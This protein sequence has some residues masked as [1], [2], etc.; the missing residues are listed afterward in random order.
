MLGFTQ[1]MMCK[2][3][4]INDLSD[5]HKV[6]FKPLETRFGRASEPPSSPRFRRVFHNICGEL[7]AGVR[8]TG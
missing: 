8:L 2:Y 5:L 4:R 1:V 3:Y 7:L 6:L